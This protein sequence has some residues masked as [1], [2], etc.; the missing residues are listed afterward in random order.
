M[1][2]NLLCFNFG[3]KSLLLFLIA[4]LL[5]LAKENSIEQKGMTFD[6]DFCYSFSFSS[7][8]FF[9]EGREKWKRITKV[10]F[11]SH[12]F[13][14]DLSLLRALKYDRDKFYF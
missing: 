2:F 14:L 3:I 9:W 7:Y 12:A 8:L 1:S 13:L 4:L 6:H 10:V 11:K 5:V